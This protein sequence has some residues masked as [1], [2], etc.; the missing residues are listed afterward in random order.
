MMEHT[1]LEASSYHN[2]MEGI[3]ETNHLKVPGNWLEI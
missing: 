2:I 3:L 1:L